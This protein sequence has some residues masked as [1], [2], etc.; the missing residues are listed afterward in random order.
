MLTFTADPFTDTVFHVYTVAGETVKVSADDFQEDH[1]DEWTV[2][3]SD[4]LDDG[5]TEVD[6]IE[7]YAET[8]QTQYETIRLQEPFEIITYTDSDGDEY[9]SADF[10]RSEPHTDDNYITEEE[11]RD[12]Q[13]RHDELIEKYEDSQGGGGIT[14]GDTSIPNELIGLGLA[15]AAAIGLLR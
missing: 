3:L 7:Y 13:E 10:E 5:I 15:V 1:G 12:Q 8:E 11:W 9:E 2:D 4:D 6:H 14:I